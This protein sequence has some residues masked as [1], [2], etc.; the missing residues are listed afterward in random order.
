MPLGVEHKYIPET[1]EC[2]SMEEVDAFLQ[3]KIAEKFEDPTQR[4]IENFLEKFEVV[5]GN[6]INLV[7]K[8]VVRN[9]TIEAGE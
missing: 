5:K 9:F 3:D 6:K 2:D 1:Y 4:E 7:L 8:N